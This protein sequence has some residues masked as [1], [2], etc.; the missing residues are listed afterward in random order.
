MKYLICFVGLLCLAHA[1]HGSKAKFSLLPKGFK[2]KPKGMSRQP[3][4][5]F[6][7]LMAKENKHR[8]L[9]SSPTKTAPS[10][11]FSFRRLMENATADGHARQSCLPGYHWCPATNRNGFRAGCD[12]NDGCEMDDCCAGNGCHYHAGEPA[13]HGYDHT[14]GCSYECNDC[15]PSEN[16]D[17]GDDGGIPWL[18]MVLQGDSVGK[19]A[20]FNA[21]MY[22]SDGSTMY[23]KV[24]KGTL[25][26]SDIVG[27]YFC[28]C[29]TIPGGMTA[30][31]AG[32]WEGYMPVS[33]GAI[34][35]H[36]GEFCVSPDPRMMANFTTKNLCLDPSDFDP[37]AMNGTC[38][39]IM[40]MCAAVEPHGGFA[41]Q[42]IN[43]ISTMHV[44]QCCNGNVG[45][46]ENSGCGVPEEPDYCD[47]GDFDDDAVA[48][49][50]C[51]VPDGDGMDKD[52][53]Y[54]HSEECKS[55]EIACIAA[56]GKPIPHNPG[57]SYSMNLQPMP[58]K[59]SAIYSEMCAGSSS[60]MPCMFKSD[61]GRMEPCLD[62]ECHKSSDACM[63][64][65]GTMRGDGRLYPAHMEYDATRNANPQHAQH[66]F[67]EMQ[68]YSS[69]CCKTGAYKDACLSPEQKETVFKYQTCANPSQH[70]PTKKSIYGE[71][72]CSESDLRSCA[73]Y[74][75]ADGMCYDPTHDG[76]MGW[77][78]TKED[79]SHNPGMKLR[80]IAHVDLV[81]QGWQYQVHAQS[82]C[83]DKQL[84]EGC[85]LGKD[86]FLQTPPS[87]VPLCHDMSKFEPNLRPFD[88]SNTTCESYT[89]G[90]T[91]YHHLFIKGECVDSTGQQRCWGVGCTTSK[92]ICEEKGF[93]FRPF[94]QSQDDQM[95][96]PPELSACCGGP[97]NV[98][99]PYSVTQYIKDGY[100]GGTPAPGACVKG[101][102]CGEGTAWR[103]GSG[104]IPTRSGMIEACKAAR[105]K[106]GWTCEAEEFC[107][108]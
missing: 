77:P 52:I 57:K 47:G 56:R 100:V 49:I 102:C 81:Y 13:E 24:T 107:S 105:G 46:N 51:R 89:V 74:A 18:C 101:G 76:D 36:R 83:L 10:P 22:S 69:K 71:R 20:P 40:N 61:E 58:R 27:N 6:L 90:Y 4:E 67:S 95:H 99:S 21:T 16:H 64:R 44:E 23:G 78:A 25:A 42:F 59:C 32:V 12:I 54:C 48:Y 38:G 45:Y 80:P 8:R 70:D 1:A 92:F 60:S 11:L 85:N 19:P 88:M 68:R 86:S 106:W 31:V 30:P 96:M 43:I 41:P 34:S 9:S 14:K 37:M 93:T 29:H 53:E 97:Q 55:S 2:L 33:A 15:G 94:T 50:E 91:S 72:S 35:P 75:H 103:E 66:M 104:C 39:S 17:G 63:S 73:H 65:A 87:H 7:E 3:F 84:S 98:K 28:P 82:C 79:C 5:S 108:S 62:A 26:T